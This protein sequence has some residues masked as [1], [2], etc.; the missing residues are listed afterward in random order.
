MFDKLK[1]LNKM[2]K[3]QAEMKKELEQIFAT[4]EKH[5]IKVVMRGDKK[6]ERIEIDEEESKE[7]KEVIND[8]MK[9]IDKKVEKQMRGRLDDLGLGGL[10]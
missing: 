9:D 3:I 5:G 6:I 7:L 10:Q 8:V 2:R 1:N 4:N